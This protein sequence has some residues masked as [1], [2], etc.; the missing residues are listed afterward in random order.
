MLHA[1]VS[2]V[3]FAATDPKT[4]ALGGAFNLLEVGT[5]NHMFEIESGVLEAEASELLK[6][7]FRARRNHAT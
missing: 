3:V 5:H 6:D 1:R 7:F 4:G 2:R